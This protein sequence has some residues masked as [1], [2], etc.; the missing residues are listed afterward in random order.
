MKKNVYRREKKKS[1]FYYI[2][3]PLSK[4]SFFKLF[5]TKNVG[6]STYIAFLAILCIANTHCSERFV[7]DLSLL[8]REV[9]QLNLKYTSL[10][11]KYMKSIKQ[12][13]VAKRVEPLGLRESNYP[14]FKITAKPN[15]KP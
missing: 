11:A 13:E 2:A 6:L 7:R 5:S 10:Q 14:P 3:T 15:K 4:I 12:S 9:A 1:L 8:E